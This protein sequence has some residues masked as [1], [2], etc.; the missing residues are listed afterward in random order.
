M[1]ALED[2]MGGMEK[3]FHVLDPGFIRRN[4]MI[5]DI[6]HLFCYGHWFF[7][8]FFRKELLGGAYFPPPSVG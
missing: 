5:D 2:L 3:G 1:K 4:D 6:P 8:S 7:P